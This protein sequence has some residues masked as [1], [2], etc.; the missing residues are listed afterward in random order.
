MCDPDWLPLS[1][2]DPPKHRAVR[3]NTPWHEVV[4]QTALGRKV[5]KYRNGIGADARRNIEMKMS[6]ENLDEANRQWG[7]IT[8]KGVERFYYVVVDDV[9]GAALGEETNIVKV[10]R[11]IAGFV[12]GYPITRAELEEQLAEHNPEELEYFRERWSQ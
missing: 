2:E 3:G 11:G 8:E 12:H 9:I 6:S 5:A 1:W 10:H 7:F 4:K